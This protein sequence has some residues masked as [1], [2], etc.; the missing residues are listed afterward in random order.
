MT[1]SPTF[2]RA[3]VPARVAALIAVPAAPRPT[4]LAKVEA[5]LAQTSR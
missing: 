2:A 1:F 5:H 4:D 3:L